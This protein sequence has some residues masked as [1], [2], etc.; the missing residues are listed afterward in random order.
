[1]D[2]EW[3]DLSDASLGERDNDVLAL[4]REE[5]LVTFSFD[6]LKRRL[7]LHPETLSRIL[8]RLEQEGI[9]EKK[10]EG[11]RVTS[12]ISE[13]LRIPAYDGESRV[14]LLQT[15]LPSDVSVPQLVSDLRGRW[16][17]FLR[18]LGL[19]DNGGSVTLKWVTE[20]G[21]IQVDANISE[22]ALTIEAKFLQDK[23][24]NMALKSSYQLLTHISRLCSP[25]RR[26]RHVAYYGSSDVF[27]M[28]A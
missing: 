1:M 20:D 5:D 13:F 16:F 28:P 18:W 15:F 12:R 17:G 22:T 6:G 10:P 3:H 23:N 19:S 21:G 8:F 27:L 4:L 9:V 2:A 11:Y 26:A 14:P 24:M 25:S 7:G